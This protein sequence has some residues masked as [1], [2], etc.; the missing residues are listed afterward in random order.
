M[1]CDTVGYEGKPINSCS[2]ASPMGLPLTGVWVER[3]LGLDMTLGLVSL[4]AT[5][6][7]FSKMS[8]DLHRGSLPG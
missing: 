6:G 8:I 4:S 7:L 1:T 2:R 3:V 5:S